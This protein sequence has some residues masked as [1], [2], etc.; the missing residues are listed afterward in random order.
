MASLVGQIYCIQ[1]AP[2]S[3][4][5]ARGFLDKASYRRKLMRSQQRRHG[6]HASCNA[7]PFLLANTSTFS[8]L[9]SRRL[10]SQF[11]WQKHGNYCVEY[12]IHMLQYT[13]V[14][15]VA[16]LLVKPSTFSCFQSHDGAAWFVS[17][18]GAHPSD[19]NVPR[20][21]KTNATLLFGKATPSHKTNATHAPVWQS[22]TYH[23]GLQPDS[24]FCS[25]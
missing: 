6:S 20:L 24:C 14:L 7:E 16:P 10:A 19:S 18:Y 23:C 8:R 11:P 9:V 13:T 2:D 17:M 12:C 21:H 25:P 1:G 22:S 4:S 15:L 3:V 5:K